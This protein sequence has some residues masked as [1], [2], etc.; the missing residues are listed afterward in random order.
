MRRAEIYSVVKRV[1]ALLLASYALFALS[2]FLF[3]K[4]YIYQP[5]KKILKTPAD[6]GLN[7]ENVFFE[8]PVGVKL[9]GWFYPPETG[10]P[11]VL[12]CHGN[13]DNISYF[14]DSAKQ[15]ADIGLGVF[16]FDYRGYG[17]SDGSPSE[18]GT[19]LDALA[20]W[21][22]LIRRKKMKSPDIIVLGRSL[23]GPIAAYLAAGR[24]PRAL[25]LESTFTSMP[26]VAAAVYPY[27]PV[28]KFLRY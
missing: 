9:N 17:A 4:K 3:Q 18:K 20:A 25:F 27:L 11:V 14:I 22:Y 21:D 8:S 2:V 6:E 5:S 16:M 15:L 23:G 12:F 1:A 7:Y 28:R 24:R 26:D 10:M 13:A 19:Y